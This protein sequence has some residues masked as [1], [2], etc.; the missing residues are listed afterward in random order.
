MPRLLVCLALLLLSGAAMAA[1]PGERLA[2]C[3]ACHGEQGQSAIE[4]V[5][6][7]GAQQPAYVLIQLY[8]FRERLRLAD[9][10]NDMARDL[11]DDDLR[12]F[13]DAIAALPRP[14]PP[15]GPVDAARMTRIQAMV[16]RLHCNSCHNADLAGRDNIPRIAAQREDYLARTLREYKSNSRHGYDAT[17]ADV[18]GSVSEAEIDELAYYLARM[19]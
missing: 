18:M 16:Q 9:P 2:T 14:K 7:L 3:L 6:S 15:E 12:Q 11:S 13:A 1:A 8:M 19:P 10:M 17:M 4:N 5:P